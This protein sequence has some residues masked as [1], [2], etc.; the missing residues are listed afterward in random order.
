MAIEGIVA[1]GV[2][3]VAK[4]IEWE[5]GKIIKTKKLEFNVQ[6]II[7]SEFASTVFGDPIGWL[8]D[9][10]LNDYET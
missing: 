9:L 7:A 3:G 1:Y 8:L 6:E 4:L 10:I 2:G 5:G